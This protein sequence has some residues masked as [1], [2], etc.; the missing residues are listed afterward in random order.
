MDYGC[1]KDRRIKE[2]ERENT[3]LREL[4]KN[5]RARIDKLEHRLTLYS[6]NSSKPPL[7]ERLFAQ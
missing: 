4:V 3:E 5:L 2:L 7:S 1:K 6:S